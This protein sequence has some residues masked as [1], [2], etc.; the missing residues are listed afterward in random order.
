MLIFM[1]DYSS[2]S[3]PQMVYLCFNSLPA[4]KC[5]KYSTAHEKVISILCLTI[6]ANNNVEQ[7]TCFSGII[8][9]IL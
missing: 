4:N 9:F 6:F 1:I 8:S 3:T 5:Q 2:S 7:G